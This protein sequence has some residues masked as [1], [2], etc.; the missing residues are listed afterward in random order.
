VSEETR[1]EF[2]PEI[3]LAQARAAIENVPNVIGSSTFLML[4]LSAILWIATGSS[5]IGVWLAAYA[6]MSAYRVI[7]YHRL[8][9]AG[10]SAANA[11]RILRRLSIDSAACGLLWAVVP[12]VEIGHVDGA[13]LAFTTFVIV[14]TT[15]STLTQNLAYAPPGLLYF[16]PPLLATTIGLI[17]SGSTAA[18]IIGVNVSMMMAMMTRQSLRSARE[19]REGEQLRLSALAMAASLAE[20][21]REAIA[22]NARLNELATH[23][24]L[25][26][27]HNRGAFNDELDARIAGAAA[28]GEGLA[29]LVIDLDDFKKIND[30]HG[31]AAGDEV[32]T[33][34]AAR[35]DGLAP[36]GV[37]LARLGG[38]EFAA[39][40]PGPHADAAAQTLSECVVA[41][42]A[43]PLLVEGRSRLVGTSVGFA[44]FPG[45]AR[46]PIDLMVSA[47]I[48]LYAAKER[49]KNRPCRYDPE[50]K[51]GLDRRRRLETDIVGA[52]AAGGLE[53]F[54][55]P[56]V[57]LFSGEI[58]G[59]EALVR[60]RH[61]ELGPIVPP[62]IVSAAQ[63]AHADDRLTALVADRA[64]RFL[65][66]LTE[67][68]DITSAVAVNVSPVEFRDFSPAGTV[69]A[70]IAAHGVD[71]GRV[72]VEITEEAVFEPAIAAPDLARLAGAGVRLAIDDFGAG[73]FSLS[74]FT[75]LSLD[76]IKIDRSFITGIEANGRHQAVVATILAL[77]DK[78]DVV[79]LA[80][81]VETEAEAATLR[82]LGCTEAQGYLFGR[83]MPEATAL[84]AAGEAGERRRAAS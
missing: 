28:N 58:I 83:P 23:D 52:I 3:R 57:D 60:W 53:V 5:W 32:L 19:F 34:V 2:A 36:P 13:T 73:Y 66:A 68:G 48:A 9:V 39:I 37:F 25:T 62:D 74:T 80:E 20:A 12:L 63:A 6:A 44:A 8:H 1:P 35:L 45:H 15:S 65:V 16:L 55:Q 69:L 82:R 21:N 77:A 10:V 38:D 29:L 42:M 18:L 31:H 84:A 30:T 43:E 24:V 64:C 49:G 17:S 14:G 27:L 81:G 47:D 54:F 56:Q 72:E 4:T 46:T 33:R 78:L 41:A 70:A 40:V 67:A 71:P 50:M 79:A 26:R 51:A 75:D 61:P 7:G 76:R 11:D 59:H 22:A